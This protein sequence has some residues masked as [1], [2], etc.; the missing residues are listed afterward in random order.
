MSQNSFQVDISEEKLQPFYNKVYFQADSMTRYFILGFFGIGVLLSFFYDTYF[1]AVTMGGAS[2]VVFFVFQ[3]LLPKSQFLRYIISLLF[4]NFGLQY[5]FQMHGLYE[6]HFFFFINL[7]VLLF[8]EDWKILL[9]ATLYALISVTVLYYFQDDAFFKTHL[10]LAQD[11][12]FTSFMLHFLLILFYAGLCLRWSM[13]QRT[14]TRESGVQAIMMEQQINLMDA[15]I[16]FADNISQGNLNVEYQTSQ[17]DRLGQS[18]LNM[19]NSLTTSAKREEREKF[20]TTGLAGIG[21]ILRQHAE[22]LE[23]LCDRVIEEVVKYMKANQ[24]EIFMLQNQDGTDELKLMACRAWN[25]KK[26]LQKTVAIGEGLVGQTAREKRTIFLTKVPENYIKL[27]SGLGEANPGCILIVPL[28]SEEV[29][30]GVIELAAFKTFQDYEISFLEKVGESIASTMITTQNNQRTKALLEK[31]DTLAEQMRAQDEAIRQ[32]LE[33]MQATQEEMGRKEKEIQRLLE[34]SLNNEQLLKEKIAEISRIEETNKAETER[35]LKALEHNSRIMSQVI[36][37]LPEKIFLKD[38]KGRL[39]MLNSA[40]AAGYNKPAS[41]L[42]GKSDFDLFPKEL[43]ERYWKV[44]EEIILSGKP[45]T[46]NE[47]FPAA[48]GE[49]R[50]LY[51]V[52]MPFNFPDTNKVGILGYQVDITDI[53]RMENKIKEAEKSVQELKQL[54]EEVERLREKK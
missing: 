33:E 51:T 46:M 13:M 25:R 47:E 8:Y 31:S 12:T 26:Y 16:V 35:I 15:N 39:L 34:D 7:T 11:T 3:A 4:W 2:L 9:P 20:I 1:L 54:R 45:L 24:G 42:I 43:A 17:T 27:T 40:L 5:L 48:N 18:L 44:E 37:E 49:I 36:E 22:S 41:D 10:P 38:E 52:K 14:Q 29:V 32:N 28:K 19:R 23:V 53:K 21:E 50:N 30:V 6:M